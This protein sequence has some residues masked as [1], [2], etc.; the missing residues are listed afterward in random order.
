MQHI[1]LEL[2]IMI[3][4][5]AKFLLSRYIKSKVLFS[6]TLMKVYRKGITFQVNTKSLNFILY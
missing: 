4:R 3:S 2:F 6:K 5:A 1:Y